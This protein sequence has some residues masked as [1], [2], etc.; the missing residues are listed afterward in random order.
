MCFYIVQQLRKVR[1]LKS[2]YTTSCLQKKTSACITDCRLKAKKSSVNIPILLYSP[3]YVV[4]LTNHFYFELNIWGR[5]RFGDVSSPLSNP[6]MIALA[7][8]I[9]SR[10]ETNPKYRLSWL[11]FRL[12]PIT[13][14]WCSG[15]RYSPSGIRYWLKWSSGSGASFGRNATW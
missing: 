5:F 14:Y 1:V 12:S 7:L 8:P 4:E 10:C 3:F 6:M 15:I 13:K 9:R 2:E 11:L